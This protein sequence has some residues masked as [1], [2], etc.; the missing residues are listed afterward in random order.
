MLLAAALVNAGT[1]GHREALHGAGSGSGSGSGAG[2]TPSPQGGL[3]LA[4]PKACSALAV[5][6]WSVEREPFEEEGEEGEGEEGEAKGEGAQ[7]GRGRKRTFGTGVH[8]VTPYASDPAARDSAWRRQQRQGLGR[9]QR[10]TRVAVAPPPLLPFAWEV[11][12]LAAPLHG[13]GG[14]GAV[15][16]AAGEVLQ[17]LRQHCDAHA[18]ASAVA[19]FGRR[20]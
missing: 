20:G 18:V 16:E 9:Q 19:A 13:G 11:A 1:A 17:S 10:A 8:A 14:Q 12:V 4:A 5:P 6:A 7:P 3:F 2:G 15:A